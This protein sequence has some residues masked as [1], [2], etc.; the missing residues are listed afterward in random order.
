MA[1]NVSDVIDNARFNAFH[2]WIAFLCGLMVFLDGYDLTA[3]SYAAPQFI[4]LFGITRAMIAPV[5]SAGLFGLT[6]GALAFGLV[7]DRLGAK[8]TFVLCGIGVRCVLA[9]HRPRAIS[10]CA[11]DLPFPRRPD[12][13]R[14]DPDLHRHRQR[15]SCRSTCAPRLR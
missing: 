14:R 8:R 9:G 1:T 5:F 2:L 4:H 6:I 15:L 7:A 12:A 3:I 10:G 13:G 11:A